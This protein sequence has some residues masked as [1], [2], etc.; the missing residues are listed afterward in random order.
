MDA[1]YLSPI[2]RASDLAHSSTE[3]LSGGFFFPIPALVLP[4]GRN[5]SRPRSLVPSA[6]MSYLK[7]LTNTH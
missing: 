6:W 2:P 4:S 7:A 5:A 1:D 3:R